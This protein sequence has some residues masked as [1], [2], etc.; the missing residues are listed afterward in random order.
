MKAEKLAF[1]KWINNA[2]RLGLVGAALTAGTMVAIGK[3][4]TL[5]ETLDVGYQP[6]QPVPYSHKLHAGEMGMDCRFCHS[7]VDKADFAAV[8]P[9]QTCMTCHTAIKKDSEKL[10]PIRQAFGDASKPVEWIKVH[11]LPDFVYFSHK[12]HVTGGISCVSCHGRVDQMEVVQQQKPLGMAWCIEC[13][14]NPAPHIRPS[15]FVTK[16]D[17]EPPMG[18]DKVKL[19]EKLIDEKHI[20]PQVHC[21]VCHR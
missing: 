10:A 3:Y 19:G 21:A 14:R 6:T 17:W 18:E 16:L 1:P 8:P 13:H 2:I 11:K 15:E 7:T 12:A 4:L 20:S 9:A 5:P